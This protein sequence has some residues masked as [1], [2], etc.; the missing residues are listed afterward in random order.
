VPLGY[1]LTVVSA[2]SPR[3]LSLALSD[4]RLNNPL[5]VS[6]MWS[7][8]YTVS[9][10][11]NVFLNASSVYSGLLLSSYCIS[12]NIELVVYIKSSNIFWARCCSLTIYYCF[13]CSYAAYAAA[14]L[15]ASV[16][17]AASA[18]AFCFSFCYATSSAFTDTAFDVD[19]TVAVWSAYKFVIP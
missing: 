14:F 7:V 9:S 12:A 11:S 6:A 8:L 4:Y 1:N 2:S 10:K 3:L 16:C 17:L 18:S 15:S 19:L 13:A 5:V